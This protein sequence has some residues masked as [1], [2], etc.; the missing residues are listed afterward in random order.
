MSD[1]ANFQGTDNPSVSVPVNVLSGGIGY[2]LG[3][4]VFHKPGPPGKNLDKALAAYATELA[5]ASRPA[6]QAYFQQLDEALR[7]GG[8]AARQP[9][10]QLALEH[11]MGDADAQRQA[12][13]ASVA[14]A[15]LQRSTTAAAAESG[16]EAAGSQ[17]VALTPA[18]VVQQYI[19]ASPAAVLGQA[20]QQVIGPLGQLGDIAADHYLREMQAQGAALEGAGGAV[21]S[22]AGLYASRAS[23]RGEGSVLAQILALL[24]RGGGAGA[25][26][27]AG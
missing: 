13:L 19:L 10:I 2:G 22:L 16:A 25:T 20:Q 18:D 7:T 26:G 1:L 21:G 5:G 12:T 4:K 8:V 14:Q 23:A 6:R 11:A 27:G 9:E 17:H 15:G 24:Q 3:K